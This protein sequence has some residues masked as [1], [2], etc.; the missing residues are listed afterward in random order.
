MTRRALTAMRKRARDRA[1][2]SESKREINLDAKEFGSLDVVEHRV[3]ELRVR[4][5]H[6]QG[7]SN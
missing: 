1:N 6:L 7:G 4:Q 2:E 5:D 3:G